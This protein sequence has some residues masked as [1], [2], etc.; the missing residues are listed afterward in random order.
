MAASIRGHRGSLKIYSDGADAAVVNI[1]RFEANQDSSFMRTF[2]A[3]NPVPEGDQSIEGWSGN[4]DLEIKDE[5]VDDLV[6][7]VVDA[8]QAGIGVPDITLVLAEEYPDGRVVS[9]VYFDVQLRMSKTN[10][11]LN[12]KMTKRIDWQASGR[13]R[14]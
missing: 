4:V 5:E 6:D 3:G 9:Y 8:N 10:P 12:E 14:L 1:T 13:K 11:G 7:S 2:Y